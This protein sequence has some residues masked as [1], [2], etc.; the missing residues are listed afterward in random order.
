MQQPNGTSFDKKMPRMPAVNMVNSPANPSPVLSRLNRYHSRRM[1][2]VEEGKAALQAG[3]GCISED[4][5]SVDIAAHD[6]LEYQAA[7]KNLGDLFR[8]SNQD[9]FNS[10]STQELVL[11]LSTY[12]ED[13]LPQV[14][15]EAFEG[16]IVT[17]QAFSDDEIESCGYLG[18]LS[19]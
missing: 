7:L 15:G 2:R 12:D 16:N 17:L 8:A 6:S 1:A 18:W 13:A 4:S 5:L 11:E 14:A 10:Q 3:Y 9:Y 19:H